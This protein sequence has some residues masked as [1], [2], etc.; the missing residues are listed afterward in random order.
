M[1]AFYFA[2]IV[3]AIITL[4]AYI[5]S[6][7]AEN[8]FFERETLTGDWGGARRQWL[9]FGVEFGLTDIAETFSNPTGG[10]RQLTIYDGLLT[11]SLKLDLQK[12]INWPGASFLRKWT[13]NSFC[14][15]REGLAG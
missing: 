10:L 15:S 7:A 4:G 2:F 9:D 14:F 12:I 5:K 6:F 1:R 3:G 13:C 11:A 8:G